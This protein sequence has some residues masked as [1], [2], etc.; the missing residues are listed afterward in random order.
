MDSEF[1]ENLNSTEKQIAEAKLLIAQHLAVPVTEAKPVEI[2]GCFSKTYEATLKDGRNVIIQFRI[3]PLEVGPFATAHQLLGDQVPIIEAI[4]APHLTQQ[5]VWPFYMSKI[6]G[7]TWLEQEK[8]WQDEQQI[9]CMKSLGRLY[10][11]C[12][13]PGSSDEAVEKVIDHLRRIRALDEKDVSQYYELIDHLIRSA[14]QLRSLPLFYTHFD[15][16]GMN[17]LS[18]KA[19]QITGVVD[20]EMASVQPFGIGCGYIHYLAGE[21]VDKQWQER[22]AYDAMERGFWD[23]LFEKTDAKI[24]RQLMS[25]LDAVQTSVMIGTLFRIFGLEGEEIM[26]AERLL[27]TLPILAKYRIPALRGSA[28][29]YSGEPRRN[30]ARAGRATS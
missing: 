14:P 11:K 2:Q 17:I 24:R 9:V 3:E 1:P 29:A 23:S 4:E 27:K 28:T 13:M 18:D 25:N 30:P 21:I 22:P 5:K 12:F 6:P 8:Q 7:A 26:V 15:L 20:W 19:G 16:N 10:A